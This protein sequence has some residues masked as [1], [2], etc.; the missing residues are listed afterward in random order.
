[1][2]ITLTG[3]VDPKRIK[4]HVVPKNTPVYS[5]PKDEQNGVKPELTPK[6]HNEYRL[7]LSDLK[8]LKLQTWELKEEIGD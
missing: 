5:S 6:D 2:L 7:D 1:M 8:G 4:F 3:I